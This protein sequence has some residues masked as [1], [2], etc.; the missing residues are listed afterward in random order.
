V[1]RATYAVG[2]YFF[3]QLVEVAVVILIL[4]TQPQHRDL[5]LTYPTLDVES[6]YYVTI[7]KFNLQFVWKS[8]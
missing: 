8:R 4:A 3:N 2:P 1:A 5:V 6:G 7:I